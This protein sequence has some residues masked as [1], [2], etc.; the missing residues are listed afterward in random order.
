MMKV[1]D[2]Q[3][4]INGLAQPMK[5]AGASQKV[6]D[7]LAGMSLGLERFKDRTIG[8]FN[9]F[10]QMASNYITDGTLP[11]AGRRSSS[12]RPGTPKAPAMSVE[13]AAQRIMALNERGASDG[14][15]DYATIEAEVNTLEP[16]TVP[17][18]KQLAEQ[19]LMTVP[20]NMR[21]KQDLLKAIA[22]G[23]KERKLSSERPLNMQPAEQPREVAVGASD[24]GDA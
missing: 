2:L 7:D 24:L 10:L 14:S 22:M 13:D 12:R 6:L 3:Q 15:L 8:E 4:F 20:P 16:M 11:E 19:V 23:I 21:T 9:D 17:Q 5:N 18:L 1:A